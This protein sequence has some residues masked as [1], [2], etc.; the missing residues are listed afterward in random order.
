MSKDDPCVGWDSDQA[1]MIAVRFNDNLK[2]AREKLWRKCRDRHKGVQPCLDLK[3]SKAMTFHF[4]KEVLSLA[5]FD[6]S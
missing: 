5:L 4:G 6:L 3:D 1:R 2:D